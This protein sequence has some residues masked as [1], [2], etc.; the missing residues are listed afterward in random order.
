MNRAGIKTQVGNHAFRGD[1]HQRV[2]VEGRRLARKRRRYYGPCLDLHH[3]ALR[4]RRD[5]VSTDE[6][7]RISI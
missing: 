4:S 7:E 3:K 2:P 6:V 1:R 5:Q